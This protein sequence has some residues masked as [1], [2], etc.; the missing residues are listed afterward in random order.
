MYNKIY[1]IMNEK[2]ITI[3]IHYIYNMKR[4]QFLSSISIP[5]L[6]YKLLNLKPDSKLKHV[7]LVHNL[8]QKPAT[9]LKA[10]KTTLDIKLP[11]KI[12]TGEI[13]IIQNKYA[14][15]TD[16][17]QSIV[18]DELKYIKNEFT[19][20]FESVSTSETFAYTIFHRESYNSEWSYIGES[21]PLSI[22]NQ[23]IKPS[24]DI[25]KPEYSET[26]SNSRKDKN[27]Y[28]EIIYEEISGS[29]KRKY[30]VSKQ[31]YNLNKRLIGYGRAQEIAVKSNFSEYMGEVITKD[32]DINKEIIPAIEEIKSIVQR[33]TWKPDLESLG[34]YEYV[35]TPQHT[36]VTGVGDCKDTTV[37]LNS[38]IESHLN[39]DTALIF[40]I[41]HVQTGLRI[42][43]INIDE[44]YNPE[45]LD[46]YTVDGRT[47]TVI[48]ST[49]PKN[50]GIMDYEANVIYEKGK[51]HILNGSETMEHISDGVLRMIKG[52]PTPRQT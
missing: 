48:E 19:L 26:L 18:Y 45:D 42:D 38:I 30:N 41:G 37:L 10:E 11:R 40:S 52:E 14:D 21:N 43:N 20:E 47:Y 44:Y 46:T 28:Y 4:R 27:G 9:I 25:Y 35:R 34:S 29:Y 31:K 5:I 1:Y 17:Y 15:I 6:G 32:I 23:Q 16:I 51:Y 3:D 7:P 12:K 2:F 50:I 36:A 33:I 8:N 22:E 24:A 39:I 13:L 49:T